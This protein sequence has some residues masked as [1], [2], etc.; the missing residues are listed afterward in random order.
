MPLKE[1]II[2][3]MI[4]ITGL[5]I[6]SILLFVAVTVSYPYSIVD[7]LRFSKYGVH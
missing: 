6:S 5:L 2:M 3:I 4:I 1:F 7:N